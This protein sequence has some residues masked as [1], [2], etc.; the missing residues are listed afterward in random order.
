V[1]I[2]TFFTAV[3]SI[4]HPSRSSDYRR[5]Q[6]LYVVYGGILLVLATIE[7]ATEALWCQYLWIDHRNDPGGPLGFYGASQSAWYGSL[8]FAADGAA[9]ILGDGL[10]VRSISSFSP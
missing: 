6:K 9:N 7:V 1:E 5:T 8:G 3:Y 2:F 10:L 4:S